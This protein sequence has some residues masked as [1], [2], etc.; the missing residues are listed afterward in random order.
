MLLDWAVGTLNEQEEWVKAEFCL[1][2]SRTDP[3]H[4]AVKDLIFEHPI[5]QTSAAIFL[6]NLYQSDWDGQGYEN[7]A[8]RDYVLAKH[9]KLALPIITKR[10][11]L[12][13]LAHEVFFA[14]DFGRVSYFV[15]TELTEKLFKGSYDHDNADWVGE[16]LLALKCAQKELPADRYSF[17]EQFYYKEKLSWKNYHP[18]LVF[19]LLKAV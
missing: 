3:D 15:G 9:W 5:Y 1:L 13:I 14:T 2:A 19:E 6:P 16:C 10:E 4:P 11:P 7:H 18:F 12:L 8:E 17:L